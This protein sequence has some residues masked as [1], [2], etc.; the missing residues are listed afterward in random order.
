[1]ESLSRSLNYENHLH[2]ILDDKIEIHSFNQDYFL[3]QEEKK[4]GIQFKNERPRR[5]ARFSYFEDTDESLFEDNDLV[6]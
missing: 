6:F 4:M 1:M 2:V 5:N 3:N